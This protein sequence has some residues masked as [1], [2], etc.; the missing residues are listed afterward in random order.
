METSTHN[1]VNPNKQIHLHMNVGLC[2]TTILLLLL[3]DILIPFAWYSHLRF[4]ACISMIGFV[5]IIAPIVVVFK[6]C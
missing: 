2:R 1:H 4:S 5:L 3:S 6:K